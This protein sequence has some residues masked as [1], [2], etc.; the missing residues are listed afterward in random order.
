MINPMHLFSING[1]PVDYWEGKNPT[2]FNDNSKEG[3]INNLVSEQLMLM[4]RVTIQTLNK[5]TASLK[6]LNAKR[7]WF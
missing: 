6:E 7:G 5:F 4:K 3:T 2:C 1:I